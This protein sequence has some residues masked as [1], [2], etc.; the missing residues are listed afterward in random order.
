MCGLPG[1]PVHAHI[2]ICRFAKWNELVANI[3][4]LEHQGKRVK[5]MVMSGR[6]STRKTAR[7]MLEKSSNL[8][9]LSE[10]K[11]LRERETAGFLERK[12][13]W[14]RGLHPFR[15]SSS[16][17]RSWTTESLAAYGTIRFSNRQ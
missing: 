2:R 10:A 6:K 4:M 13:M 9:E 1:W 15:R 17:C 16:P 12:R 7:K 3:K 14:L 11:E 5:T 8:P